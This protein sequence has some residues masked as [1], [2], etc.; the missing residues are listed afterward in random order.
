MKADRAA[1]EELDDLVQGLK[2]VSNQLK[3]WKVE[4][5]KEI[6]ETVGDRLVHLIDECRQAEWRESMSREMAVRHSLEAGR[7]T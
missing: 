1:V 3:R 6:L 2:A 5:A 7:R 4:E